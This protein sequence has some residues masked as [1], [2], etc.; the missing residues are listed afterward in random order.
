M[1]ETYSAIKPR[2]TELRIVD[3]SL[4]VYRDGEPLRLTVLRNAF[5][6][7]YSAAKN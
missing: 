2:S 3:E 6:A 4:K 5:N 7:A 1:K